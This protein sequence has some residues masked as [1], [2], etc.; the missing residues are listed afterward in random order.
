[1]SEEYSDHNM[2][3][4]CASCGVAEVDELKLKECTSCDLVRYC[5][6]ACQQEHS[7]QHEAMCN[8]RAAELRDEMFSGNRNVPILGTARSA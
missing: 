3:V 2:M 8:E 5:S 4:C 1:M 6:D 7:P